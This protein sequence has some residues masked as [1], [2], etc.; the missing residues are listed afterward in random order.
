MIIYP[1]TP[2]TGEKQH[3]ESGYRQLI[4]EAELLLQELQEGLVCSSRLFESS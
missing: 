4:H 1:C 3:L 2:V